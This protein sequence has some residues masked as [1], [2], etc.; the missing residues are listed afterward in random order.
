M[1][2]SEWVYF[3]I[4]GTTEFWDR[5]DSVFW[6]CY[7]RVVVSIILKTKFRSFLSFCD[8]QFLGK[9]ILNSDLIWIFFKFY[10]GKYP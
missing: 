8:E 4:G 2:S 10:T 1:L 7:F 5:K 9:F 6:L 3:G